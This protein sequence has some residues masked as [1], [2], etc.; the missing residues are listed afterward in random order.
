MNL[1]FINLKCYAKF[2][3][4]L[5]YVIVSHV[6][7][8]TCYS[9][10]MDESLFDGIHFD[11]PL[12]DD[13]DDDIYGSRGSEFETESLGSSS[14][15]EDEQIWPV[16]APQRQLRKRRHVSTSEESSTDVDTEEI[17]MWFHHGPFKYNSRVAVLAL[18][19]FVLALL[20]AGELWVLYHHQNHHNFIIIVI[21]I[22][23]IIFI[24]V[25]NTTNSCCCYCIF[26]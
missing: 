21:I 19:G 13:D 6:S 14:T 2:R 10:D 1:W 23:I 18:P 12:E 17:P 4:A 3:V 11:R 22:I 5:I 7:S 26:E 25:I 8:V 24:I 16:M 9:A 20:F 15:D